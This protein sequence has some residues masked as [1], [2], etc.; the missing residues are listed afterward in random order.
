MVRLNHR[1]VIRYEFA[2]I[3]L[4]VIIIIVYIVYRFIGSNQDVNQYNVLITNARSFGKTAYNYNM[5]DQKFKIYLK[6][7]FD[8]DQLKI[9]NPFNQSEKCDEFAS[10][11]EF[12][13]ADSIVTLKCGNFLIDRFTLSNEKVDVYYVT[14]W[15]VKSKSG[16][17][18]ESMVGYKDKNGKDYY[19][20]EE[21][22][23]KYNILNKT[24][25]DINIL[26]SK[27][28]AVENVV[29]RIKTKIFTEGDKS[30]KYKAA[31]LNKIG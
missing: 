6:E 10:K 16:D 20:A 2:A 17:N 25:Y 12:I 22:V 11:V 31:D 13:G 1:G 8:T 28:L 30:C 7:M 29:Y 27:G 23:Y 5:E 19:N 15:T 4:V 3:I 21:F 18:V 14:D 24:N 26:K 9:K